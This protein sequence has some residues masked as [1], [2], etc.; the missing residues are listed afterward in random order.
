[1]PINR[2]KTP[3]LFRFL[4]L[5]GFVLVLGINYLANSLPLNGYQPDRFR[6]FIPIYLCRRGVRLLS[7]ELYIC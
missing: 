4:N 5:I 3:E 2:L 1:M 7:G 6:I